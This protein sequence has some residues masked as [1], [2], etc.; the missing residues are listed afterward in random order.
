MPMRKVA[1]ATAGVL[2]IAF[3]LAAPAH[4]VPPYQDGDDYTELPYC[5]GLVVAGVVATPGGFGL[6]R[7]AASLDVSVKYLQDLTRV[8]CQEEG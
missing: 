7:F 3:G 2:A 8:D 6:G 1:V 5:H 4:A